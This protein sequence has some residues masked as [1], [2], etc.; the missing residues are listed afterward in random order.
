MVAG[1]DRA[2][3]VDL[4][5]IDAVAVLPSVVATLVVRNEGNWVGP[6]VEIDER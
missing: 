4:A 3:W 6:I 1:I 2:V 5:E